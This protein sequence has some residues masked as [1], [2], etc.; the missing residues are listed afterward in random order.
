MPQTLVQVLLPEMGESVA[1]GSVTSWRKKTGDFVTAGEPLV[2]VTTDKVD[3]EVPAPA[4]GKLTRIFAAEGKTVAV[5]APLAE[6]D[7]AA[8]AQDVAPAQPAATTPLVERAEAVAAVEDAAAHA[9]STT[10]PVV[11]LAEQGETAFPDPRSYAAPP[12]LA[13]RR[14]ASS[15]DAAQ[16]A[17]VAQPAVA[18]ALPADAKVTP[19]R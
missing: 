10:S 18:P 4:S 12:P 5:G 7:T 13:R 15:S 16:P 1:D 8:G 14:A 19:L 11:K 2:D 6:I 3:V 17:V 9:T